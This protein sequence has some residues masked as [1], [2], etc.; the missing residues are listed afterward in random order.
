LL[1]A[2]PAAA[3]SLKDDPARVQLRLEALG[4]EPTS[5]LGPRGGV[6]LGAAFLLTDQL[7][8]FADGHSR[9]APGGGIHSFAVGLSA[10]LDITPIEPYIEVA[11]ATLTNRS[12]LG[13]SAAARTGAGA[14]LRLARA[15][16]VG[17][18]VRTYTPFNGDT[19]VAGFEA[20]LRLSFALGAK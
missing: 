13:Y 9:P 11:V 8:L 2:L 15:L 12:A 4:G 5:L 3:A 16:A 7:S 17:V 20:A 19:A 10:T 18:L 14:D 1:L 6:G